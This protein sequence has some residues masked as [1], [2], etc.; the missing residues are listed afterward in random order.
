[1]AKLRGVAYAPLP[2]ERV[3]EIVKPAVTIIPREENTTKIL[4]KREEE[5]DT[6]EYK[7]RGY[8]KSDPE[9]LAKRAYRDNPQISAGIRPNLRLLGQPLSKTENGIVVRMCK[10][11][12]RRQIADELK[13]PDPAYISTC[14]RRVVQKW[15]LRYKDEVVGFAL[16]NNK[17]N[18]KEVQAHYEQTLKSYSSEAT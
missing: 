10:G 2:I 18:V 6:E 9:K 15:G 17:V 16:V 1:M 3:E 4:V 5:E 12:T 7:S 8:P 13:I 14:L 11:M